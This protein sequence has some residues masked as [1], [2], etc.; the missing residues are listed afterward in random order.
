MTYD[1]SVL[2]PA[3]S[4]LWL[5]RTVEG[6][7]ERSCDRTEV[8]VALDGE[9]PFDPLPQHPRLSVLYNAEPVGQRAATNQAARV[10]DARWV[11]KLDAHCVLSPGFDEV[12]MEAMD[13]HDDW[14][15]T[16][17]MYN[18]HAFNRRCYDCGWEEYQ[19]PLEKGCPECGGPVVRDVVWQPKP[20]PETTAMRF[21]R[22]L[23]FQYWS[24]RKKQQVWE[25]DNAETMS[26]LGACWMLTR[27]RYHA[28]N[29]CDE[30]H[31]GWGQQGTEVACKTWLSGGRLMLNRRAWFAHLFRT[32]GGDFGFPYEQ[33]NSGVE[34]AREYSRWLWHGGN[35]D[36]ATRP[37]SW[38]VDH[39][40]APDWDDKSIVYYTD[41]RAPLRISRAVQK[42]LRTAGLPIVSCSI[43]PMPHFGLNVHLPG[44]RGP[45]QMFRQ[46]LAALEASTAE[47]VFL[48][49]H[50]VAYH[51]SHF[52]F[53]PPRDDVFYYNTNVYRV[54]VED[55]FAVRV[56][57]CRQTSGLCASR[58]L[59]LEHYR[60]RVRRVEAEGY[61]R[62]MGFEPG[63][64]NRAA[65]VDDH[66]SEAW[67]SEGPN[68]DLRHGGNLT[69]S[70]WKP[71]QFR[72]RRYTA[73][74]QECHA[75]EIPGWDNLADLAGDLIPAKQAE[76]A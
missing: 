33:P 51:P 12:L 22:D 41:N 62:A 34:Q 5:P 68:L 19:G 60:E 13:G 21:G 27:E 63:T 45:L 69:P 64:H 46:I 48:C 9:W 44:E 6:V 16:P 29:I 49:E 43:R 70:R 25:G 28:M 56:A 18:L 31:S 2:I 32:Q 55:G 67:E 73:G 37:L 10:S 52:E 39:F 40:Q 59:L 72:N 30:L 71:E 26:L 8:I 66:G 1:L 57:D 4:E 23:R 38:L 3:R 35:W 54:R 53:T 24:G 14:T 47:T 36:G 65:R 17:K 74:W 11:M 76:A 50:D 42:Q 75:S 15:V 7:L 58:G 61:S 20:S